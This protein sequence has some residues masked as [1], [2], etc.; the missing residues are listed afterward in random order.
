MEAL[1]ARLDEQDTL[2]GAG[3]NQKQG[4]SN[5]MKIEEIA[6]YLKMPLLIATGLARA[7]FFGFSS[8]SGHFKRQAVIDFES[9]GAQWDQSLK[10]RLM[11]EGVDPVVPGWEN[12]PRH[13]MT[14]YCVSIDQHDHG[15]KDTHWLANFFFKP[16]PFYFPDSDAVQR[17][18]PSRVRLNKKFIAQSGDTEIIV[19]PGKDKRL[20]LIQVFGQIKPNEKFGDCLV[21]AKNK[22]VPVLN[23]LT[24]CADESLSI[25]Q[26]NWVGLPSGDI[27]FITSKY[28][29][30]IRIDPQDFTEHHPLRD[31]QSLYRLG[32]NCNEPIYAFLSFWRAYEAIDSVQKNWIKIYRERHLKNEEF[33]GLLKIYGQLLI[34]DHPAFDEYRGQKLNKAADALRDKFRNSIAHAHI[35]NNAN[36][37]TGSDEESHQRV[38]AA[39]ATLRYVVKTK[40]DFLNRIFGAARDLSEIDSVSID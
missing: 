23:W 10:S 20:A 22:I 7:G 26:E 33:S 30:E 32:L 39:L 21:E 4:E 37:L 29:S 3:A 40:L 13:T 6:A 31:A 12:P 18:Y 36:L 35:Q 2:V 9:H 25:V 11:P 34:P 14:E 19:Y 17:L 16:N 38:R 1:L 27:H 15:V 24:M 28:P 5:N 8:K